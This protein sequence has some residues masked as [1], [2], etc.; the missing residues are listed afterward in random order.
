MPIA[1]MIL[2]I[3]LL[4]TCAE[5]SDQHIARHN[6]PNSTKWMSLSTYGG[7]VIEEVSSEDAANIR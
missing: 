2:Y 5:E 6:M 7:M 3:S 4:P 1:R